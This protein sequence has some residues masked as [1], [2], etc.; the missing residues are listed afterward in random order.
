MFIRNEVE[1]T[2]AYYYIRFI[3]GDRYIFNVAKPELDIIKPEFFCIF[4][5]SCDHRFGK[6]NADDLASF[7]GYL[8]CNKS[9]VAGATSQVNDRVTLSDL[10]K[11]CWKAAAQAKVGVR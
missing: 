2:I 8:S 4:S 3:G 9:I 7:S 1:Y 10:C 11:L 6:V 5:C